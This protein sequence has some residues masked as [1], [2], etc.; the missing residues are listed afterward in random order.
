MKKIG[1]RVLKQKLNQYYKDKNSIQSQW[2]FLLGI[3][4]KNSET[5][6]VCDKKIEFVRAMILQLT[7]ILENN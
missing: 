2:E 7:T 4:G 6:K 1:P 3:D 5:F